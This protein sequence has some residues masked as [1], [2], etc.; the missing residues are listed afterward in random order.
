MQSSYNKNLEKSKR[1][2]AFFG[3]EEKGYV[4]RIGARKSSNYYS[5]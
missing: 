2:K 5:I 1:R 4:A 3:R